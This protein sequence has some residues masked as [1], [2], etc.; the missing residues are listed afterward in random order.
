MKLFLFDFLRNT[1]MSDLYNVVVF[2][3]LRTEGTCHLSVFKY[4]VTLLP[5]LALVETILKTFWLHESDRRVSLNKTSVINL[6]FLCHIF[7]HF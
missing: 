2:P 4:H 6:P 5:M 1:G 7:T 3:C